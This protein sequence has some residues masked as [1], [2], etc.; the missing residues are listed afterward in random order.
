MAPHTLIDCLIFTCA[1]ASPRQVKPH[2]VSRGIQQADF[3]TKKCA[4]NVASTAL[5]N[6]ASTYN[7]PQKWHLSGSRVTHRPFEVW[8]VNRA[9]THVWQASCYMHCRSKYGVRCSYTMYCHATCEPCVDT[10]RMNHSH[11]HFAFQLLYQVLN[12]GELV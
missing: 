2:P 4:D 6:Q 7:P 1:P 5:H 3:C 12:L 9:C 8:L 11:L 10:V